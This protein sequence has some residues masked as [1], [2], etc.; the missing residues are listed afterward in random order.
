MMLFGIISVGFYFFT[1]FTLE[2]AV[3][4]SSR[5]VR[6]G[7]MQT[8]DTSS[9]QPELFRHRDVGQLPECGG[10]NPRRHSRPVFQ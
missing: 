1:T 6:T 5:Y 3:E 4:K 8:V 10:R 7:Q 2:N 9:G